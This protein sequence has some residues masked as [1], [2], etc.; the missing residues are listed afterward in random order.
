[1]QC[2]L[3]VTG[4]NWTQESYETASGHARKRASQLRKLGYVVTVSSLGS[5][6]TRLGLI[7]TTMVDIRPGVHE[8]TT[9]IPPV[10]QVDWPKDTQAAGESCSCGRTARRVDGRDC[11]GVVGIAYHVCGCGLS[12]SNGERF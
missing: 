11:H 7:K 2:M 3:S 1:M 4:R 5:Q 12:W 6:V 9:G 10:K 8:D